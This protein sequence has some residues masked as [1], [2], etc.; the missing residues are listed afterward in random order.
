ML[1]LAFAM[2]EKYGRW[3]LKVPEI[4]EQ[5]GYAEGTVRNKINRGELPFVYKDPESSALYAD[6]RDLAAYL[7]QQ[8]KQARAQA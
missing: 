8:R 4:A 1:V 2:F 3:R 7:D 5:L 6:A